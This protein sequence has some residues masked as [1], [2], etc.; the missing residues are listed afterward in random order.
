MSKFY[1]TAIIFL[2]WSSLPSSWCYIKFQF[3]CKGI[4]WR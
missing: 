1:R 3:L 4:V 2:L